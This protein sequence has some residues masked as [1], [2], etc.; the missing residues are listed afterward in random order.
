M[1]ILWIEFHIR[2]AA[3]TLHR[4]KFARVLKKR[5]GGRALSAVRLMRTL[6]F[7]T[8]FSVAL[9]CCV[10]GWIFLVCMFADPTLLHLLLGSQSVSGAQAEGFVGYMPTL[11]HLC[12]AVLFHLFLLLSSSSSSPRVIIAIG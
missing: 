9:Q 5:G 8:Q 10:A 1:G 3:T 6:F 12:L 11:H 4:Q 2:E 7:T